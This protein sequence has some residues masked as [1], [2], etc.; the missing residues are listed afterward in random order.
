MCNTTQSFNLLIYSL[1]NSCLEYN[2][3]FGFNQKEKRTKKNYVSR[4]LGWSDHDS[5]N[6]RGVDLRANSGGYGRM[7]QVYILLPFHPLLL[8]STLSHLLNLVSLLI[9]L[10]L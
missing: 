5:Y 6:S 7:Y 9:P 3:E 1:T 2:S 4:D 10:S 8:S